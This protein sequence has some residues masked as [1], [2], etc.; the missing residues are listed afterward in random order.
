M[1]VKTLH[2]LAIEIFKTLN[3]QNPSFMRE[4]FY[5]SP[6]VSHKKQ[7]LF[8]QSHKTTT[9]GEKS[10]KRSGPQMWNSLPEKIK[11]VTNLVDFKK[12]IKNCSVLNACATY[13][14]LKMK[15]Q[16]T[17]HENLSLHASLISFF[18]PI[19]YLF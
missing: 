19:L 8:V 4:I 16:I 5:R 15:T 7:N 11:L 1:E 17:C 3:N 9:F 2:I 10:L 12:P 6:S 18:Y 14:L 13:V